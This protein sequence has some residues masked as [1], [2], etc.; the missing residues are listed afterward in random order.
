MASVTIS[1]ITKAFDNIEVLHAMN[2]TFADGE[3]V[4]LLGPSGLLPVLKSRPP[5]RY[6]LET[7]SFP[8]LIRLYRLKNEKSA[9]FFNLMP[10]GLI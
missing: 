2:D 5:A 9:W 3:F 1:N 10:C 4:T 8:A 7:R 6:T